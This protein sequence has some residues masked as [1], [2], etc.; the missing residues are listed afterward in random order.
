MEQRR[1]KYGPA[2]KG[3]R[4]Q[5]TFRLPTKQRASYEA[6]AAELGITIGSWI[7]LTL[8]QA[9]G[10]PIPDYIQTE[11]RKAEQHRNEE[12]LPLARSA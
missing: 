10:L 2:P 12:E 8:A 7:V 1:H 4:S 9:E 6:R 5:L 11:L 3:D